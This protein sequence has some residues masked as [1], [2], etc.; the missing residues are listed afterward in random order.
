MFCIIYRLGRI[1]SNC[2]DYIYMYCA[3]QRIAYTV[4]TF[5]V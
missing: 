2:I 1:K 5:S 4:N 3:I